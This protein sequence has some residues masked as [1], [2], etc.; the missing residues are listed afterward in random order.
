MKTQK[1]PAVQNGLATIDETPTRSNSKLELLPSVLSKNISNDASELLKKLLI[2][3]Y[4]ITSTLP[5]KTFPMI[6]ENLKNAIQELMILQLVDISIEPDTYTLFL[7]FDKT[8]KL[9]REHQLGVFIV[10][11][12]DYQ[13]AFIER[14]LHISDFDAI[15]HSL[16]LSITDKYPNDNIIAYLTR[17]LPV[18]IRLKSAEDIGR[19]KLLSSKLKSEGTAPIRLFLAKYINARLRRKAHF[20]TTSSIVLTENKFR[21][22]LK[23]F[24]FFVL[25][26]S[27]LLFGPYH[28]RQTYQNDYSPDTAVIFDN[29]YAPFIK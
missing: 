24:L 16:F 15:C 14:M 17:Y 19:A 20:N 1:K 7:R 13:K 9:M 27:Y 6:D 2:P 28:V 3:P 26:E 10:D 22:E 25:S 11:K 4:V 29:A 18:F 21:A 5:A 23:R 8:E 12:Y